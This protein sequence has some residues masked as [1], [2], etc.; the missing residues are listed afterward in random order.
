MSEAVDHEKPFWLSGNFAPTFEEV[1]AESLEV[2]GSIPPELNGRFFRNGANPKS[3]ESAH[4][5][6][7]NG[8]LHGVELEN[9]RANWYRNRYVRTPL[10]DDDG[11]DPMAS[12]ADLSM[13]LANTH[14]VQHAGKILA[15]EEAHWPYEISP[16]LDTVGPHDFDGRLKTGMT[17]HPKV[18]P[19]TGELLFFSYGMMPPYVTYH[20]A[21]AAGRLVQS[22]AI[23][24]KGATMVHDFNVTRNHVVFMD[25]PV[26]F[27]L[28][29]LDNGMP[30]CWSDDY[31]RAARRYASQRH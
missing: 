12:M 16:R 4:W 14:V 22:E 6:L 21:D 28:N 13:S 25:L 10:L 26:V 24:V 1:T 2:T 27:D 11:S 31:G 30:M 17:A 3:G 9:G 8:M 23:E 20:R 19:E 5:F 18:C 29:R 7:G 15:L